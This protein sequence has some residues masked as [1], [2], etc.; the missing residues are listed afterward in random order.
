MKNIHVGVALL[1]FV[2]FFSSSAISQQGKIQA[3]T[4]NH[5]Q[6]THS[7]QTK[8]VDKAANQED[9][10]AEYSLGEKYYYGKGVP[11]DYTKAAEWYRKAAERG[12]VKAQDALGDMYYYG[13][14][15]P[16]DYAEAIKWYRKAAEQAYADAQLTLGYMYK[17]GLGVPKDY[18]K[19]AKWY[20]K[21]AEQGCSIARL[22]LGWLLA[23]TDYPGWECLDYGDTEYFFINKNKIRRQQ[24]LV[25]YWTMDVPFH[26]SHFGKKCTRYY[27]VADCGSAISGLVSYIKYDSNGKIINSHTFKKLE[28]DMSPVIPGSIGEAWLE[29][30]CLHAKAEARKKEEAAK[31]EPCSGTGLAGSLWLCCY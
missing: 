17:D 16:Q 9:G 13:W 11:Q 21:A 5:P 29:Y 30:A 20:R 14:D 24:N 23:K 6:N 1:F 22:P 27:Y 25:W 18:T 8:K 12:F 26:E 19:A 3:S 28:I 15:I 4:N 7:E 31:T 10:K 2:I